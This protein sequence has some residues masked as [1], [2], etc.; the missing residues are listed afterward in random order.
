MGLSYEAKE[1]YDNALIFLSKC[2]EIDPDFAEA[3]YNIGNIYKQTER[4]ER[5]IENYNEIKEV[6]RTL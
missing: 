5:A 3:W 4:F 6:I 2:V 1:D